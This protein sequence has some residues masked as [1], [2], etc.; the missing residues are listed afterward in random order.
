MSFR[1]SFWK[2]QVPTGIHTGIFP[3][4]FPVISLK[5]PPEIVTEIRLE[6]PSKIS[7]GILLVTA[8][9]FLLELLQWYLQKVSQYYKN[10][11]KNFKSLQGFQQKCEKGSFCNCFCD[12]IKDSSRDCFRSFFLDIAQNI[13]WG[14]FELNF[15]WESPKNSRICL[16]EFLEAFFDKFLEG[17]LD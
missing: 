2:I 6:I 8:S 1:K 14:V 5:I 12:S 7:S 10:S 16:W 3:R 11:S 13:T 17:F 9:R 15:L 4:D